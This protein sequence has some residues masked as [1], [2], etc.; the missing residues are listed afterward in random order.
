MPKEPFRVILHHA[1]DVEAE[2]EEEAQSIAW[3]QHD[4]K[5]FP[6]FVGAEVIPPEPF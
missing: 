1:Y 6:A 4:E 3:K 5:F 2:N